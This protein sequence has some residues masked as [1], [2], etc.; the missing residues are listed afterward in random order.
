MGIQCSEINEEFIFHS[1]IMYHT[2][3]QSQNK[4]SKNNWLE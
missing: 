1:G 4:V 3:N 2:D